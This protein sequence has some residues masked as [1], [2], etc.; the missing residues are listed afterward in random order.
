MALNLKKN[1][2]VIKLSTHGQE[3]HIAQKCTL[4]CLKTKQSNIK[5]VLGETSM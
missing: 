5:L 1:T 2:E 3:L 4:Y